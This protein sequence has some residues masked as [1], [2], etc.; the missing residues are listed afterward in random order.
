[1]SLLAI[2]CPRCAAALSPST[3]ACEFCGYVF[4]NAPLPDPDRSEG[5]WRRRDDLMA[6]QDDCLIAI[7]EGEPLP[8][9][10]VQALP[11][12]RAV[13]IARVASLADTDLER[14][15]LTQLE[16]E[17]RDVGGGGMLG[18]WWERPE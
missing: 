2:V 4:Q 9:R 3:V 15:S 5:A 10:A 7:T 16:A 11:P 12:W 1:M 6:N 8:V 13:M 14:G 17:A 18:D